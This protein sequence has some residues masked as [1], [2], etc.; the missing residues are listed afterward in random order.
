MLCNRE[1]KGQRGSAVA[2]EGGVLQQSDAG[3]VDKQQWGARRL[4]AGTGTRALDWRI[5]VV[6]S[7]DWTARACIRY[8]QVSL[9][10]STLQMNEGVWWW[11]QRTY[12]LILHYQPPNA[13]FARAPAAHE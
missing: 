2:H 5:S 4:E 6:A 8:A 11:C 7:P 13:P 12:G 1:C 9:Y 10:R 3:Q